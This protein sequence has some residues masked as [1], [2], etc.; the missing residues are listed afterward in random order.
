MLQGDITVSSKFTG[1]NFM[2]ES[3]VINGQD[4]CIVMH[5][6]VQFTLWE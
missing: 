2:I 4:K 1:I 6:P 3:N 5:W